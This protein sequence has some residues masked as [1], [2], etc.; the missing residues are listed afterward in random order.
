MQLCA[1]GNEIQWV[2]LTSWMFFFIMCWTW[3]V[4]C[5]YA[6][7][8][9]QVGRL[10]NLDPRRQFLIE[11]SGHGFKARLIHVL[12]P[13]TMAHFKIAEC[14]PQKVLNYAFPLNLVPFLRDFLRS[15]TWMTFTFVHLQLYW[16]VNHSPCCFPDVNRNYIND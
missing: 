9:F 3:S 1:L 13:T 8:P 2:T 5:V 14:W 10:L 11:M 12:C 6:S 7:L 4:G 16:L 15:C